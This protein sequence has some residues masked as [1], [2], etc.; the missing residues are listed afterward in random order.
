MGIVNR[1]QNAWTRLQQFNLDTLQLIAADGG[2]I[3]V[4]G[5]SGLGDITVLLPAPGS[6]MGAFVALATVDQTMTTTQ[7]QI[8][9]DLT[10]V[11]LGG[12]I[13]RVGGLFTVLRDGL[14]SIT[15]EQNVFQLQNNSIY[16]TWS[17]IN[18]V[19][20][21]N[22]ASISDIGN[23]G[24]SDN[25]IFFLFYFPFVVGDTFNLQGITSLSNGARLDAVAA[26]PPVP[27]VPASRISI[28]AYFG[29]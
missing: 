9:Y 5:R 25:P 6:R 3:T 14:Y 7:A 26:A 15:A 28:D 23:T 8:E 11:D 24:T 29:A 12:V 4:N 13:S 2:K 18:G 21:P 22:S 1:I 16:T 20:V 27:G 17:E 10:V 19:A